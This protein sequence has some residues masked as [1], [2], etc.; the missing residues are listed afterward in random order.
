M[1][2]LA[3]SASTSASRGDRFGN[4]DVVRLANDCTTWSATSIDFMASVS[5]EYFDPH[6]ELLRMP[7]VPHDV[8]ENCVTC[9]FTE[10]QARAFTLLKYPMHELGH[11]FDRIHQK[12]RNS[13]RGEEY[14]ENFATR[15]FEQISLASDLLA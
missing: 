7:G 1:Y 10:A 6:S 2:L 13:S 14:A 15:H 12:H 8:Q 9:K 11:H 3:T 5:R 4:S